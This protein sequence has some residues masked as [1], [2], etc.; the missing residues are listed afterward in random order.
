MAFLGID[1]G[2]KRVG[3][4]LSEG[5]IAAPLTTIQNRTPQETVNQI[6]ALCRSNNVATVVIGMP[7]KSKATETN[8]E[9]II[10]LGK[11]IE[12]IAEVMVFFEP[13]VLTTKT[14]QQKLRDSGAG[15]LRRRKD[16]AAAA[17]VILQSYL[18]GK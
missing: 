11:I 10:E 17:A 18:D 13:E 14:A 7:E 3:I 4:A 12:K 15:R 9:A 6:V 5:T 16:D 8:R 1:Y 2:L